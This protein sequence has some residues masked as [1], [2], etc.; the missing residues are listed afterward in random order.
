M[1]ESTGTSLVWPRCEQDSPCCNT[2]GTR[3]ASLALPISEPPVTPTRK[4]TTNPDAAS[5]SGIAPTI[6]TPSL[7]ELPLMNDTK[8][9]VD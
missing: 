1:L 2:N 5:A 3:L 4:T 8:K 7:V 9:P 6:P